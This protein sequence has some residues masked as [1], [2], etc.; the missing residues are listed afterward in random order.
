MPPIQTT[1][2]EPW[3][4]IA[5]PATGKARMTAIDIPTMTRPMALLDRSK[6]SCTHGICATHVPIAAPL[7]A[8]TPVVAQR[9]VTRASP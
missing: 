3:R 6:R 8:N 2:S 1:R 9:G 5:C 7:T 4:T